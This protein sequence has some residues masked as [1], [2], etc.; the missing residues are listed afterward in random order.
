MTN[1]G[2]RLRAISAAHPPGQRTVCATRYGTTAGNISSRKSLAYSRQYYIDNRD[3]ILAAEA[4]TERE[5]KRAR[6]R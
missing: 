2:A 3:A 4:Q 6:A 1:V 5:R